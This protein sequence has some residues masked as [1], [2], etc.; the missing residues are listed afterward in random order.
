MEPA[1]ENAADVLI[2]VQPSA[3]IPDDLVGWFRS[4]PA[5]TLDD[6]FELRVFEY[7]GRGVA[8]TAAVTKGQVLL[9]CPLAQALSVEN[10]RASADLGPVLAGLGATPPLPGHYLHP[11]A[12]AAAVVQCGWRARTRR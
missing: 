4:D 9:S 12:A 8:S 11:S 6:G 3:E 7:Q 5:R 1:L 10:A 2:G